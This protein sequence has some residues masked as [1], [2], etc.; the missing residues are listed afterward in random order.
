MRCKHFQ[1]LFY[2]VHKYA[3]PQIVSIAMMKL[4][5]RF[6]DLRVGSITIHWYDDDTRK[7]RLAEMKAYAKGNQSLLVPGDELYHSKS[8]HSLPLPP[9]LEVFSTLK[10]NNPFQSCCTYI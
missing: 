5:R 10:V 4:Q 8:W 7:S 6:K 3:C 2:N 1:N 9:T